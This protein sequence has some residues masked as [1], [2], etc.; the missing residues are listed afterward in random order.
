MPAISR[1]RITNL[2]F[3]N[4]AKRYADEIFLFDSH[5]GVILLENGGGKTVFV[6]AVL[7]AVLPHT[8]LAERKAKDTFALENSPAHLAIE[9]IINEKPRRYA[10][11][12]VTLFSSKE[13]MD[14]Y[15]Y[16][17]EYESGD[18]HSLENIP[19]V[20]ESLQG[21]L[22]PASK[23]EMADY[24]QRMNRDY[25][26]AGYFTTNREY[27]NYIEEN[28]QI[29]NSEWKSVARINSA[30][31]E[32]EGFFEGCK[33]TMQLVDQLL[34]PTVQ[35]AMAGKGTQ[36]F[37]DTF[38][39]QREHFKKHRQLREKI[40]ESQRVEQQISSYVERYQVYE[41]ARQDLL[42]VKGE[43]R[44][45]YQ[46]AE[47]Q[48]A[49]CEAKLAELQQAGNRLQKQGEQLQRKQA[50]FHWASLEQK[51]DNAARIYLH[52]REEYDN[53]Q[54]DYE[55]KNTRLQNLEI[56]RLKAQI[57]SNNETIQY[58]QEQIEQL[59][60]DMD[61][62]D[63]EAKIKANAAALHYCYL[64]EEKIFKDKEQNLVADNEKLQLDL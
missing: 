40:E 54:H 46:L 9:W 33:T 7:Q 11:T 10:L 47:K 34:I 37:V 29:I 16:V 25:L 62:L 22:R 36:D 17:Y 53:H 50:S 5:N 26:S 51:R 48:H 4:G 32:I 23:E 43:A 44:S 63:L 15:K 58:Y 39:K 45:L 55:E 8:T 57:E 31:G 49:Q 61:I 41:L 6:Q 13:G 64:Q 21:Q 35:A 56:A 30:E 2:V 3:E 28:F 19:F 59:S 12:A 60:T 18:E 42:Q 14:S 27:Q 38:E 52:H 24:Y 20:R 1:I